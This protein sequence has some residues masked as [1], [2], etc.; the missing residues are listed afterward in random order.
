MDQGHNL[1][2]KDIVNLR[3]IMNS[4]QTFYDFKDAE[5]GPLFTLPP[6]PQFVS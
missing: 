1:K 2:R 3:F 5:E 6:P 4:K